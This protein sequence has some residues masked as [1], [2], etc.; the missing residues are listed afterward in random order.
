MHESIKLFGDVINNRWF[1]KTSVIIFLNKKDLF[2]EKIQK[3]PLTY[4]FEDF[5]E[6]LVIESI[7]NDGKKEEIKQMNELGEKYVAGMAFILDQLMCCDN[8]EEGRNIYFHQ[9]CA[10]DTENIR[11][12]WTAVQDIFLQKMLQGF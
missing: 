10:T 4:A 2:K 6:S 1:E 9:T 3:V 7:K 11:V 5:N 8:T 12:V